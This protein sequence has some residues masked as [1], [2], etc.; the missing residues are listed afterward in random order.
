MKNAADEH[1]VPLTDALDAFV[2]GI[3]HVVCWANAILIAVIIVQVVLRY[4]F[5]RGLVI[6]E[7]LQWHLYALAAM[8]GVSYAQVADSH[9][10]VD[11]IAIRLSERAIRFW[12]VF[13]IVVFVFPFIFVVFYHSLDFVA[14]SWR[15]NERSDAPLGLPWRWAIKSVIPISFGLLGFAVLSRLIRDL[16]ALIRKR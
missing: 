12:E 10:R 4:G 11:V 13:G 14:E 1:H 5:G 15:V 7:E 16:V 6:L 8:V 9:I 3:G 2:R